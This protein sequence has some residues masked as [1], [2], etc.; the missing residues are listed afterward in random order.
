MNR[1]EYEKITDGKKN[2]KPLH[3]RS[4]PTFGCRDRWKLNHSAKNPPKPGE[5]KIFSQYNWG[6]RFQIG[7]KG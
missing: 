4:M 5:F 2:S 6:M 3:C 1:N 7:K